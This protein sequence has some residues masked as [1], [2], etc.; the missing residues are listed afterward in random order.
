MS[1]DGTGGICPNPDCDGR[2]LKEIPPSPWIKKIKI[3]ILALILGGGGWYLYQNLRPNHEP[4]IIHVSD[5]FSNSQQSCNE[6]ISENIAEIQAQIDAIQT[7]IASTPVPTT[8]L[9][10]VQ[11]QIKD[12]QTQINQCPESSNIQIV[13]LHQR[14][15]E[16]YS[17]LVDNIQKQLETI[18]EQMSTESRSSLTPKLETLREQVEAIQEAISG[19]IGGPAITA[20]QRRLN[21]LQEK[22]EQLIVILSVNREMPQCLSSASPEM[23][24]KLQMFFVPPVQKRKVPKYLHVWMKGI[25]NSKINESAFFIMRREIK[26]GEF[27]DYVNTLNETQRQKLGTAWRQEEQWDLPD[28]NPVGFVPWWAAN[29]YAQWLAKKTGC[30]LALPTYNQWVAAAIS[31][32]SPKLAVIQDTHFESGPKQRMNEESSGGL[33]L[34]LMGS[35]ENLPSVL[36]LLGNLREW[37][38]DECNGGHYLLGADYKTSRANIL[39]EKVCE[40]YALDTIGFRLV[41]QATQ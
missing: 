5:H 4:K 1:L 27:R 31:Y 36:D 22:I 24:N 19:T 41:L 9:K 13:E 34:L 2:K 3:L 12:I 15:K 40:A 17:Q 39:G 23:Q 37:S 29:G 26:V 6:T 35:S 20:L 32:A 21:D 25:A 16:I 28:E 38:R 8:Q 14:I 10:N 11:K 33:D 30:P 7:K 18:E